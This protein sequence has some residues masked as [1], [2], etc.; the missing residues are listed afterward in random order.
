MAERDAKREQDGC[1]GKK[2]IDH[3]L[4]TAHRHR[5]EG[6]YEEESDQSR[7]QKFE[8]MQKVYA[9]TRQTGGVG[10]GQ[11]GPRSHP[12]IAVPVPWLP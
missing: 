5:H 12:R 9:G 2:N 11:R 8:Q 4:G 6:R 10:S 1:T 7:G 3:L